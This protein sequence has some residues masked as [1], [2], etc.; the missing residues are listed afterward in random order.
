MNK[1]S[2]AQNFTKKNRSIMQE[3]KEMIFFKT[4]SF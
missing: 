3:A 2:S 1:N 4:I